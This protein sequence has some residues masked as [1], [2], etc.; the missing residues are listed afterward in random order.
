MTRGNNLG[1]TAW[2]QSV[3]LVYK[4]YG[5]K[6]M[7]PPSPGPPSLQKDILYCKLLVN[8]LTLWIFTFISNLPKSSQF[9]SDQHGNFL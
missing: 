9:F 3:L 6:I 4:A 8:N 1:E 5:M 2:G 7:N